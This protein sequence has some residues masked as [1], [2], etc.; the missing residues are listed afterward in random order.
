MRRVV[1]LVA[2]LATG[3]GAPAPSGAPTPRHVALRGLSVDAIPSDTGFWATTT[4]GDRVW[5][6]LALAGDSP[7]PVQPG[8]H[9]DVTGVVVPHGREFAARAG[10]TTNP[11][12]ALLT[13]LGSH[14]EVEQSGIRVVPRARFA[15]NRA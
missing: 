14:V 3:C 5:V 1:V 12:A 2:L 13:G 9:V 8:E 4:S 10:V 7:M 6:E 11:D 15:L